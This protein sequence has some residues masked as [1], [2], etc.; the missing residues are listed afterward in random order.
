MIERKLLHVG[1]LYQG[2][3]IHFPFTVNHI[4]IQKLY[5][6]QFLSQ[7]TENSTN[8]EFIFYLVVSKTSS[9]FTLTKSVKIPPEINGTSVCPFFKF[10]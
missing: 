5:H 10:G 6:N 1:H 9:D 4:Y 2:F 3:A 7:K 8:N